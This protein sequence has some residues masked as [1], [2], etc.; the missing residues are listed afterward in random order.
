ML[1]VG[2]GIVIGVGVGIAVGSVVQSAV[3]RAVSWSREEGRGK[4]MEGAWF[5][6][7]SR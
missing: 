5:V 7:I 6:E 3:R 1:G 4:W 2:I